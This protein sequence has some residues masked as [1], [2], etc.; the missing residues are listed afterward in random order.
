MASTWCHWHQPVCINFMHGLLGNQAAQLILV[1]IFVFENAFVRSPMAWLAST[2]HQLDARSPWKFSCTARFCFLLLFS[3]TL[4]GI[5][6]IADLAS[7]WCGCRGI[8]FDFL[9]PWCFATV[10]LYGLLSLPSLMLIPVTTHSLYYNHVCCHYY[11]RSGL[12]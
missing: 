6:L 4:F 11:E 2:W 12:W 10:S 3:T 8:N 7:T 9:W 1:L 5:N